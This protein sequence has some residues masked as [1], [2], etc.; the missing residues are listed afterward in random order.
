MPDRPWAEGKT[1]RMRYGVQW[2]LP[3]AAVHWQRAT[4]GAHWLLPPI[5]A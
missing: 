2:V 3:Q 5:M 4:A 1:E